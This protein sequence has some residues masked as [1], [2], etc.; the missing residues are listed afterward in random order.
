MHLSRP[1]RAARAPLIAALALALSPAPASARPA[2]APPGRVDAR[3]VR[4]ADAILEAQARAS[5]VPG[6][7]AALVRDGRVVWR[8]TTGWRDVERRL[9]VRPDTTFRLASVS[10][11]LAATAAMRLHDQGRLD[12]DAPIRSYLPWLRNAWPDISVR[13]LAAHTSGLPHYQA[14]DEARGGVHFASVRDA[15]ALFR[16]RPLQTEP[17]AAYGYSTWGFTLLSAVVEAAAGRPYLDLLASGETKGL[18]IRP[19]IGPAGPRDSQAYE[20]IDGVIRRAPGH[21]YSY[22]WGGAGMRASASDLARFAARVLSPDFLSDQA[23]V[24][25]WTPARTRDGQAVREGDDVVAFGWRLG[26]DASGRRHVHHGGNAIG[27]RSALVVYPDDGDSIAVLSNASWVSSITGTAVMLAAP[28]R[29][30]APAG[31]GTRCPTGVTRFEGRFGEDRMEGAAR[32][33]LDRGLCRG[34]ISTANAV[35]AWTNGFLQADAEQ[36]TVIALSADAMLDRAA[37]VLP[38]GVYDLR[39]SADGSYRADLGSARPLVIVLR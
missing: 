12:L 37:L 13:Q 21:D 23:R 16:D 36:A 32:F 19:D 28:F 2:S 9:P 38:T 18:D 7:S 1:S 39:R 14:I 15:V 22:S 5:G 10:K 30:D 34:E 35:G 17:G 33:R 26:A 8:G 20:F 4:V 6:L 31:P 24:R 3:A 25:L 27:A 11:L 29:L